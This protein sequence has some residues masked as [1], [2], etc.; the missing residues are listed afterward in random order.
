M[1]AFGRHENS[2]LSKRTQFLNLWQNLKRITPETIK[3]DS[4]QQTTALEY[5]YTTDFVAFTNDI[6]AQDINP[7]RR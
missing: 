7:W 5:K 3:F 1:S 6:V 2:E 4:A